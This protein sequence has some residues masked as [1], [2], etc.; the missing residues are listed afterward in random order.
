VRVRFGNLAESE[1]R[2][3]AELDTRARSAFA[4]LERARSDSARFELLGAIHPGLD[5]ERA[6]G[7]GWVIRALSPKFVPIA[8]RV[9]SHAP[10][11]LSVQS[12]RPALSTAAALARLP[13][14]GAA[15]FAAARVRAGFTRGHLLELVLSVPGGVG[16]DDER[17][18]AERLVWDVVGERRADH[19]IGAV[20][21]TP[22]PRRGSLPIL[23][24]P[25]AEEPTF[26]LTELAASLDA[27]IAALHSSLPDAP[28]FAGGG[29]DWT[30]F[31]LDPEPATDFAAKDDLVMAVTRLPELM[32]CYLEGSPF[33]SARFSR[34]GECFLHLKYENPGEPEARLSR[35]DALE[36]TLDRALVAAQAGR[37]IGGG[38]GLRYSYLDFALSAL[39]S[40]LSLVQRVA[41]AEKLPKRSWIQAFD[42]ELSAEWLE[43][44]PGTAPPPLAR[45]PAG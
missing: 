43:I 4:R 19:W 33:A 7:G 17:A 9:V 45:Q 44:W 27:A 20:E 13:R 26:P 34:H 25:A 8:E 31:E 15:D 28:L 38:L 39:D 1:K 29:G 42:S 35:R 16:S 14:L 18:H 30:M 12:H 3:L 6:A 22:A 32:K 5:V 11:E 40:G 21:V 23:S 10:G 2:E 41:Q 37:V 36:R 24:T